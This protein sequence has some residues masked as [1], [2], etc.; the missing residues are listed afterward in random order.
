LQAI[1][2]ITYSPYL[3]DNVNYFTTCNPNSEIG[4]GSTRGPRAGLGGSPKPSFYSL[5]DLGVRKLGD[6]VFGEPPKTARQRHAL[7]VRQRRPAFEGE[8]ASF[9]G[10][11][12]RCVEKFPRVGGFGFRDLDRGL[13]WHPT[14]RI[15][16]A[17]QVNPCGLTIK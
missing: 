13:T 5:S 14:L 9:G 6:E 10:R 11:D 17:S 8:L 16:R 7:P 1:F 3:Q 15:L 4:M 12:R 2:K